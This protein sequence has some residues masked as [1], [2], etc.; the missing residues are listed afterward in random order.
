MQHRKLISLSIAMV[1]IA[2]IPLI[3]LAGETVMRAKMIVSFA[4]KLSMQRKQ[5]QMQCFS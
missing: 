3:G 5:C 2:L 1:L 4:V